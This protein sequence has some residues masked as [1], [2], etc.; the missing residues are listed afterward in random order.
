[1]RQHLVVV[2][3]DLSVT[4]C[5]DLFLLCRKFRILLLQVG[6]LLLILSEHGVEVLLHLFVVSGDRVVSLRDKISPLRA[7]IAA[8]TARFLEI[9]VAL[10]QHSLV[11]CL[12]LFAVARKGILYALRTGGMILAEPQ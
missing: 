1:M 2:S 12:H 7:E 8:L 4:L 6:V 9:A 5:P 3:G 10:L 11:V